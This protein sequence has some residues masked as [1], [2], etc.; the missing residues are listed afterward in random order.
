M[1][2]V[3]KKTEKDPDYFFYRGSAQEKEGIFKP[4]TIEDF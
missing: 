3:Y 2:N 1:P 4:K